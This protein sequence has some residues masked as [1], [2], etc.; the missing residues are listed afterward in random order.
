MKCAAKLRNFSVLTNWHT[1]FLCQ[2][3]IL[4]YENYIVPLQPCKLALMLPLD[5]IDSMEVQLGE[6]LDAFC[7]ALQS[8]PIVSVR[9]NDKA[10]KPDF[11]GEK[12]PW[13]DSGLYLANRPQFT[14]DPLLHAGCYYVQDASSMFLETVLKQYVRKDSIVLDLCAAPGGKSTLISQWLQDEGLLVSNEVVRQRVFVLSENV[15]K[16]GNGNSIVTHN[17]AADFGELHRP[18]D[19]KGACRFL[20]RHVRGQEVVYEIRAD[21]RLD[22]RDRPVDHRAVLLRHRRLGGEIRVRVDHDAYQPF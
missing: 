1:V 14:L 20:S 18:H 5:F 22:Q 6:Q 4:L 3:T 10:V 16:W 11:I 2:R 19:G 13:C 17:R 15:Q 7:R 12:V 9:L 8:E 21:R